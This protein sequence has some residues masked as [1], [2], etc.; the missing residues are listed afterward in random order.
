MMTKANK[1]RQQYIVWGN[2]LRRCFPVLAFL[3]VLGFFTT[4]TVELLLTHI[5]LPKLIPIV[6]LVIMISTVICFL[7]A[8]Y[9]YKEYSF[10][11]QMNL[12]FFSIVS[13]LLMS[14]KFSNKAFFVS[15][16]G[17]LVLFSGTLVLKKIGLLTPDII[18]IAARGGY[19]IAS[20]M[21]LVFTLQLLT[22][23][24]IDRK[25]SAAWFIYSVFL[26]V[27]TF[28]VQALVLRP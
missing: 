3:A 20:I 8:Q 14:I 22:L 1:K 16:V 17:G 12:D 18:Q 23:F 9:L 21:L 6:V 4:L 10:E 5:N 27:T 13:Y 24:F 25:I 11:S 2:R 19:W 26:G 7:M 28:M 15:I